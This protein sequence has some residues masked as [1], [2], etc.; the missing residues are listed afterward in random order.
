MTRSICLSV[1]LLVLAIV[2]S[3]HYSSSAFAYTLAVF[4]AFRFALGFDLAELLMN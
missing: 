1:A 4:K 2:F 3:I